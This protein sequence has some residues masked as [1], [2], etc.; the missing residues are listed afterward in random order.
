MYDTYIKQSTSF[1]RYLIRHR[2]SN[3]IIFYQPMLPPASSAVPSPCT[4]GIK[5][6]LTT[7]IIYKS[8][9][10][11]PTTRALH[12]LFLLY[13]KIP[14]L[15]NN[16]VFIINL[17]DEICQGRVLEIKFV[18]CRHL[19]KSY[20]RTAGGLLLFHRDEPQQHQTKQHR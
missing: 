8:D 18:Y 7:L 2:F 3:Q 11:I 17:V 13:P 16:R 15:R 19:Y 6:T 5:H 14:K 9:T 4:P 12:R 10:T 1:K 20:L